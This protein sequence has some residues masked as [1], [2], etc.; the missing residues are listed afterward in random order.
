MLLLTQLGLGVWI[1]NRWLR[2]LLRGLGSIWIVLDSIRFVSTEMPNV[3]PVSGT[4]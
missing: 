3:R 4:L 1:P 2:S